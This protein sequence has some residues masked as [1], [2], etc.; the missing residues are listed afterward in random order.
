MARHV[1][2]GEI[3]G[4]VSLVWRRGE[5][6]VDAIGN[7]T[8]G[9]DQPVGRDTIFRIA[10]MSKPVTAVAALVL[11]EDGV[12]RLDDPVDELLPELVDRRVLRSLESP[13]DDTEPA[14]RSI[15]LRDLLTFRFGFGIVMAPP[16][17]YPITRALAELQIGSG[18]PH[19]NAVV[20]PDEWMRQFG[21][22]PLLHQPG[23]RW[24]YNTGSDVLS[25][26]IA[27]AAAQPFEVFL[28]ERIFEPL[29]MHDTAFFVPPKKRDRFVTAYSTNPVSCATE[30]YDEIDGEWA[31]APA[32]P[33]GAG[34]LVSTV[35]DYLAFARML[36][37]NGRNSGARLLSRPTIE[38][39]TTDHL[40]PNQK[41]A[42]GLVDGFFDDNGWGFGVSIVTRR[43]DIP[44]AVGSYGWNGGLG[45]VWTNDPR[46]EMI[47]MLLTQEAWT[48]PAFPPV[49][50][51]FATAA[52]TAIDD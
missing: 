39:M 14:K 27:R 5:V 18:P 50:R 34:G 35:D 21:S 42:S 3:A 52:Y 46:E 22:L 24:M 32:F 6:H 25:V 51:D 2:Y 41:A 37:T 48:S 10:S 4:L 29:G 47:T 15:T 16:D 19:P 9:R 44:Y 12:L 49:V 1:D 31:R 7:R 11:V 45:T 17:A 28:R 40:T 33:S 20:A 8:R 43:V 30:V 26:L 13:L 38:T 36:L 23:E